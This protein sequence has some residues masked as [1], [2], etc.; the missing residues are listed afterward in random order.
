MESYQAVEEKKTDVNIAISMIGDAIDDST[1]SIVLVSGDSDQ[2]P[3]VM[4]IKQRFPAIKLTVYIPSLPEDEK[5][6]QNRFYGQNGIVCKMMP[7]DYMAKH[8]LPA[9]VTR[10]D[11]FV[12]RRPSSWV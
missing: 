4:W 5:K 1:D 8:Q 3:A 12:V 10:S 2:E 9:G 7:L 11:G 6:R